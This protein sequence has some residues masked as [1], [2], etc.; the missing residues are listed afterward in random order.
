M[1]LTEEMLERIDV[2]YHE[3]WRKIGK[4]SGVG[5]TIRNGHDTIDVYICDRFVCHLEDIGLLLE[6]VELMMKT[7]TEETGLF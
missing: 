1:R 6:D 5:L 3:N 4:R 7:I 2:A